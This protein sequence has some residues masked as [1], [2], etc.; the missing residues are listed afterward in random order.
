M[1]NLK[2]RSNCA[3]AESLEFLTRFHIFTQHHTNPAGALLSVT[4][5]RPWS[6]C[7]SV[8][9]YYSTLLCRFI[10]AASD[11]FQELCWRKLLLVISAPLAFKITSSDLF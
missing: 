2:T 10:I 9:E 1:F 4:Y 3:G 11:P 7:E 6:S 8:G 5:T